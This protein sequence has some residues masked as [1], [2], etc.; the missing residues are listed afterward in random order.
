MKNCVCVCV[1]G[2]KIG[3]MEGGREGGRESSPST[4]MSWMANRRMIVQIIPNVIFE[5]PST[6]SI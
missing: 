2:R 1:S 5:L 3:R 6:I 4:E